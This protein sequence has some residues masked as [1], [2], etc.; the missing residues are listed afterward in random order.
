MVETCVVLD[1]NMGLIL[2]KTAP[3]YP[4]DFQDKQ[5]HLPGMQENLGPFQYLRREL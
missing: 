1:R 4:G 3:G 5:E 2:E